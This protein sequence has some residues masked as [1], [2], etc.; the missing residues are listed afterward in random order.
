[1]RS[2]SLKAGRAAV[3]AASF[4][5]ALP[6]ALLVTGCRSGASS[7]AVATK[8]Y[9]VRGFVVRVNPNQQTILLNHEAIPGLMEAMAME[10]KVAD[11]AVM[12]EVHTGDRITAT[13]LADDSPDGPVHLRLVDVV[14]IQQAKPD[15]KPATE[16]H[17]PQPGDALPEIALRNQSD[18][19]IHLAQ[20]RGKVLLITFV[21][22]RCPLADYCPRMS[23]NFAQIDHDLAADPKLYEK[24]HLLT[25]SF[26]PTYDTPAVLRSYGGAYT[27]KYTKETFG[28]WDFAAPLDKDLKPMEQWFDLGVTPGTG[29]T[30]AHSLATVVV[31]EDGKV[32]AFY[33]NNDWS[34]ADVEAQVRQAAGGPTSAAAGPSGAPHAGTMAIVK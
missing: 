3:L 34:V 11:P 26:D 28:H 1:M 27:G 5:L 15:Y 22:T 14:V 21:Y 2:V 20:F 13:M 18:K 33:P 4:V 10:Y 17:V 31:G 9:P 7:K 23:R 30:L 16:Y 6:V 29:N 32:I 12:T 24:T 8:S 25:V 19:T